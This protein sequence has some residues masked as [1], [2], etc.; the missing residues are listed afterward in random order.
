MQCSLCGDTSE[1]ES[2]THLLNGTKILESIDNAI[3]VQ[4]AS[5]KHIFSENLDEQVTIMKIFAK[6]L[7]VRN[8]LLKQQ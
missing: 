8:I 7:K 4:N 6:V 1:S 3:D 2:E 5:Y